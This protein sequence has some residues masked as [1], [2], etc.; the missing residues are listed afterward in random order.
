MGLVQTTVTDVLGI[1][2]VVTMIG[3]FVRGTLTRRRLR[4]EANITRDQL[5]KPGDA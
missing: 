1:V 3:L 2:A 4:R 5:R